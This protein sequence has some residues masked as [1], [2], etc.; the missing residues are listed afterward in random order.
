MKI[1][2][3]IS[4]PDDLQSEAHLDYALIK[5]ENPPN[6]EAVLIPFNLGK[7]ILQNDEA[8]NYELTPKDQI[9][10]FHQ[11]LF[12]DQPF[13]TLE[14]EVRGTFESSTQE[15]FLNKGPYA[16]PAPGRYGTSSPGGQ[17]GTAS[18]DPYKT[19]QAPVQ[20]IP[21]RPAH[22]ERQQPVNME[23]PLRASMA[24]RFPVRMEHRRPVSILPTTKI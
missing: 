21:L 10:V 8:Y 12:K 14:G 1:K 18:P 7:L 2:D 15:S 17:Y 24:P 6:R 22:M 9:F 5:R 3:L 19:Q 23:R 4:N 20:N 13:V 16:A 11:S